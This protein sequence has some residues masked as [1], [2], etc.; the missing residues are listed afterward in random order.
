[1]RDRLGYLVSCWS[2]WSKARAFEIILDVLESSLYLAWR[3]MEPHGSV[4]QSLR[5]QLDECKGFTGFV[6]SIP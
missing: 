3:L 2:T 4:I 5:P 6:R 1:M